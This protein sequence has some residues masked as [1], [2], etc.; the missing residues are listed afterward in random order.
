MDQCNGARV[1]AAGN[2]KLTEALEEMTEAL[3]EIAV[4][5]LCLN[6]LLKVLGSFATDCW[7]L[8][9]ES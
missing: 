2:L 5:V 1:P 8:E 6:R 9:K 3:E 4:V 7:K